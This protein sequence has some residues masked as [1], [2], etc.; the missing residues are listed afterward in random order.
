MSPICPHCVSAMGVNSTFERIIRFRCPSVSPARFAVHV[1]S[2]LPAPRS[3]RES[4]PVRARPADSTTPRPPKR[5]VRSPRAVGLRRGRQDER[6]ADRLVRRPL[7]PARPGAR[8]SPPRHPLPL[9]SRHP[10][11]NRMSIE[12]PPHPE[13]SVGGGPAEGGLLVSTGGLGEPV[14][15][16][17]EGRNMT[18]NRPGRCGGSGLESS[19]CQR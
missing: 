5:E 2:L 1:D 15:R 14:P 12:L 10:G 18:P 6:P 17:F 3:A 9:T 7:S 16:R 8:H 11:G 4:R 13:R 19:A